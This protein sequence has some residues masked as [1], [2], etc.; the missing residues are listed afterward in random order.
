MSN[1]SKRPVMAY[2]MIAVLVLVAIA[3]V[4]RPFLAPKTTV[5]SPAQPSSPAPN[6]PQVAVPEFH[7]DS[8][9]LF[10]K[11]QVDFGP[12]VPNTTAHK[13]CGEWLVKEFKRYGFVV[14]EQKV[15]APYYKGGFL[16]GVNIIAQYKPELTKRICIA[17]HWDTRNEA[18]KDTKDQNKPID[19]ADDGGSGIG[20]LLELARTLHQNPVD[21]GVDLI[22]FDLED[23]GDNG[24]SNDTW[25]LGSQYWAKNLHR[26]AYMP[27]YAVLLDLVG[28][29]GAKFYKE[30]IS[31]DVAPNLVNKI[32]DMANVLGYG[33]YFIPENRGGVT[34]D[35]LFVI[36]HARIPMI[37]I[38]SLPYEGEK[39][40]GDHHHTHADNMDIID[41]NV[42]KAV[43]QTMTELIYRT[44]NGVM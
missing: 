9:Y 28:A 25:C 11:K 42:L 18:E 19:G 27:Y 12:R 20:V 33:E 5:T 36:R 32:W 7:A 23:N 37:D 2:A 34:D 14:I 43:G 15:S 26:P 17:A 24:G 1:K 41:K 21:I 40:F 13:K 31:M 6:I 4:A 22:C 35:H 44:N 10:V 29:K 16:N 3:Y 30:G 8:A 39:M 38:I